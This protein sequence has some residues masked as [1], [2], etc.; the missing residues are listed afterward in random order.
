MHL[1]VW[2][3]LSKKNEFFSI[4]CFFFSFF[5]FSFDNIL[6]FLYRASFFS[7]AF[8]ASICIYN[9]FGHTSFFYLIFFIFLNIKISSSFVRFYFAVLLSSISMCTCVSISSSF[10]LFCAKVDLTTA[11]F[12]FYV[13]LR[14]NC[15]D[16]IV[17]L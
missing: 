1:V 10:S 7:S 4:N 14:C 5:L 6:M 12:S 17:T 9:S 11:K 15:D 2:F 13:I 16:R 3:Y 8:L